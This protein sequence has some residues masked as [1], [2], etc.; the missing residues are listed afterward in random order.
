M[1]WKLKHLF[2]ATLPLAVLATDV[3][4]QDNAFKGHTGGT[5]LARLYGA[6]RLTDGQV[7]WLRDNFAA[8]IVIIDMQKRTGQPMNYRGPML[9]NQYQDQ[10]KGYEHTKVITSFGCGSIEFAAKLLGDMAA[11]YWNKGQQPLF[12]IHVLHEPNIAEKNPN[13]P[14]GSV[15]IMQLSADMRMMIDRVMFV[16]ELMEEAFKSAV[17]KHDKEVRWGVSAPDNRK[18]SALP[19]LPG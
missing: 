18:A 8:E 1:K 7:A 4:A 14:S 13:L 16:Q 3:K 5:P 15:H 2:L 11:P 6:T 19:C 10:L 12:D 9:D 17:R